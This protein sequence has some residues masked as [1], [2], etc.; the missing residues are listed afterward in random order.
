MEKTPL[1]RAGEQGFV[2][3]PSAPERA[4]F[5]FAIGGSYDAIDP[6]VMFGYNLRVPQLSLDARYGLGRGWSLTGHFN[7]MFV[8]SEMLFGASYGQ[9]FGPWSYAVD[10]SAGVYFGKLGQLGFD[11]VFVAAQ[12]RPEVAL[13]YQIGRLAITLRANLLLLGPERAFV[14]G[15]SGGFDNARLFTGHSETLTVENATQGGSL[16]Y[17]GLGLLTTRSYYA[18]WLLFPDS[19]ALFT[20]P[21]LVAGY[22]F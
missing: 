7:S 6:Q 9:H 20:Y 18:L 5:R 12:Y 1:E 11:A 2:F 15:V 21:R 16:W 14:G 3:H 4:A 8:T 13:G 22:E 19:P 10:A 17:Y